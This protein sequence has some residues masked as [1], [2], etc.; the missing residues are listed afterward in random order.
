MH[1]SREVSEQHVGRSL[2]YE[3]VTPSGPCGLACT[4]GPK[5]CM[6]SRAVL[7]G[8]CNNILFWSR[9][10][11]GPSRLGPPQPFPIPS[12]SAV[13]LNRGSSD[14]ALVHG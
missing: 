10:G 2:C 4:Q 13:R 3:C 1:S 11:A 14:P 12:A 8:I 9:R 5:V 6:T 7:I